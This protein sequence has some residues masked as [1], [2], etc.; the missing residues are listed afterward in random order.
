MH[1]EIRI[2]R[3]ETVVYYVWLF[4]KLVDHELEARISYH[5]CRQLRTIAALH[6]RSPRHARPAPAFLVAAIC[7]ASKAPACKDEI[8][9]AKS[10]RHA[11]CACAHDSVLAGFARF[12]QR[13]YLG[14]TLINITNSYKAHMV[15]FGDDG[16]IRCAAISAHGLSLCLR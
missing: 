1:G 2:I 8:A 10:G 13:P 7:A 4:V 5:N 9:A 15:A 16:S 3:E 14:L 11:F 12:A 6:V